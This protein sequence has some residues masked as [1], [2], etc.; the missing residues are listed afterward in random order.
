MGWLIDM[1]GQ[2]SLHS[3]SYKLF[4]QDPKV[5]DCA[6]PID[7]LKGLDREGPCR[8]WGPSAWTTIAALAVMLGGIPGSR[9]GPAGTILQV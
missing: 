7:Y 5:E 6:L 1:G 3:F 4:G 2:K 8:D 9:H